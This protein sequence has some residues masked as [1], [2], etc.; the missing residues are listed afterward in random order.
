MALARSDRTDS[1]RRAAWTLVR[2]MVRFW[3]VVLPLLRAELRG[4]TATAEEIPDPELRRNALETL[5]GERLNAAGAALFAATRSARDPQLVRAL[6]AFQVAWDYLDTLAEQPS[7]APIANGR[8]LH[9]ALADALDPAREHADYYRLH[10]ARDDGGYL[11]ALVD[12]CREGCAALPAFATV[13]AAAVHEAQRAEVQGI[14]HSPADRREAELRQWSAEQ[15][16]V[17]GDVP[18]FELAAAGASSLAVH[19]LLTAAADPATTPA[20]ATLVCA[21][22]MPWI[23]ALSTLLDSHVD[24]EDDVITGEHSFIAYYPSPGIAR[25]RLDEITRRSVGGA[26]ALPNGEAHLVLVSGMVAMYLSSVTAWAPEARPT[27][28]AVL[29]ATGSVVR[30]LLQVLRA[31][32]MLRGEPVRWRAAEAAGAD[33]AAA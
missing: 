29:Q 5:R 19:A 15:T 28:L 6:V 20:T 22:Y 30:P 27:T 12:A 25:D 21:A 16:G 23:A 18:W 3:I 2:I 26:L 11:D 10:R 17:P 24:R 7:D 4:W 32:R 9:R 14:N 8:L 33:M 31:W 13:Q 1:R